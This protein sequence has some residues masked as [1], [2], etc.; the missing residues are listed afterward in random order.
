MP[1][2]LVFLFDFCLLPLV[3]LDLRGLAADAAAAAE[4]EDEYEVRGAAS[5][6]EDEDEDE[7]GAAAALAKTVAGSGSIYFIGSTSFP[8]IRS[9]LR[10]RILHNLTFRGVFIISE[11]LITTSDSGPVNTWLEGIQ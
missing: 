6:A 10:I 7:G 5:A 3:F 1:C 2:F 11:P 9:L 8:N 4:D